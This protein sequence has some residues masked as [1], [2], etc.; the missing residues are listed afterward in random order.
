MNLRLAG[1]A[2]ITMLL[3][4]YALLPLASAC[5]CADKP[6]GKLSLRGLDLT[7]SGARWKATAT[8][9]GYRLDC[10]GDCAEASLELAARDDDG[11]CG[12]AEA[13]AEAK[14]RFAGIERVGAN[15]HVENG[16]PY[17]LA[18]ARDGA[19][20]D[21]PVA[22]YLCMTRNGVTYSLATIPGPGGLPAY[23]HAADAVKLV[24]GM[25][26]PD[27]EPRQAAL[28][29][30]EIRYTADRWRETA[31]EE[32]SITFEC[33]PPTC[34][35]YG[36][37]AA[38]VTLAESPA[39]T[40]GDL[41]ARLA[42]SEAGGFREAD[43]AFPRTVRGAGGI[44]FRVW[45]LHSGCRNYVPPHYLACAV[46]GDRAYTLRTDIA[47]CRSGGA[48]PAGAFDALLSGIGPG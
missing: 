2:A 4:A 47:G 42:E 41:C 8:G 14:R 35:G 27:G 30:V 43:S 44:G 39:A 48:I 28:G 31:R 1:L 3:A 23:S 37:T 10:I 21:D 18:F 26:L 11:Y 7:F 12:T 32:N 34:R 24:A 13:A 6:T 25:K 36:R 22:V 29:G 9:G 20:L 17:V 33:L 45:T 16:T 15:A 38:A 19:L 40:G 46:H 5:G